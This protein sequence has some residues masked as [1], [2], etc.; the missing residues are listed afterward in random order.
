M[1]RNTFLRQVCIV[2]AHMALPAIL[3]GMAIGQREYVMVETGIGPGEA[4]D[5]MTFQAVL[6]I[7]A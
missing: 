5:Q 6:R 1:A 2:P 3:D 4:V 7:S